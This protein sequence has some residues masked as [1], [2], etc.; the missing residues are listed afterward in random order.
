VTDVAGPL[1]GRYSRAAHGSLL[2]AHYSRLTTH[3]SLRSPL[4]HSAL[5][6]VAPTVRRS[7]VRRPSLLTGRSVRGSLRS[8]LAHSAAFGRP[9]LVTGPGS[10]SSRPSGI[11]EP[12]RYEYLCRS[13][14][15][16]RLTTR[17]RT[18]GEMSGQSAV[19]R[20]S[21]SGP[22][23]S[24]ARSKRPS[25]SVSLP[26]TTSAPARAAVASITSS[27]GS[28]DVATT[29]RSTVSVAATCSTMCAKHRAPGQRVH[30][31]ARGA[32]SP[33]R[34][35]CSLWWSSSCVQT[36]RGG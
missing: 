6:V 25:T 8:P 4:V 31:L 28:V 12:G 24:T 32:S 14:S 29:G 34:P 20:T 13:V 15:S 2:T 19:T 36:T 17:L 22:Y 23:R 11:V 5:P 16:R 7:L 27:G 21:T 26:G 3:G 1:T 33:C 9:P 10:G 35:G 30:H 18:A